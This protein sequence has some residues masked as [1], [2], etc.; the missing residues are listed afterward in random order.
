[1]STQYIKVVYHIP[2]YDEKHLEFR[3]KVK[4][5]KTKLRSI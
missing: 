5:T 3:F 4:D 1:M 2:L